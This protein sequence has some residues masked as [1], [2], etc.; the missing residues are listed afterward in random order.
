M[1]VFDDEGPHPEF[2]P[3]KEEQKEGVHQSWMIRQ[4]EDAPFSRKMGN[5]QL[6]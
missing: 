3:Q 1:D 5:I 6:I 2:R 4:E